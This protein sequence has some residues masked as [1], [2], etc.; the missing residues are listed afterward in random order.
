M[1][2]RADKLR[3]R[4]GAHMAE[5]M[6][7]GATEEGPGAAASPG[8]TAPAAG[9]S[10]HD[11]VRALREARTI[12]LENLA[13]D[14]SQPRQQFDAESLDRLAK[15]LTARGQLQP[16]RVRWGQ[17]QGK[18]LIV[19]GER[20]WR[21]AMIAGMESLQ[22][23][24]VERE[25]S[26]SEIL[27]EQLVENCLREDLQ[28]IE[29]SRAFKALMDANGWSA[30]RVADELSLANSTVVKAL[31]LLELA[32]A[33][34]ERVGAGELSPAAAYEVSKLEDPV[35]QAEVAERVVREKLTRDQAAA[36]V[37]EK[38]GR[39]SGA[40]SGTPRKAD[41]TRP[42]RIEYRLDDGTTVTIS[43]PAAASG[44]EAV[45]AALE[46]ALDRAR[47]GRGRDQAA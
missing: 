19:A 46:Q 5:S 11:G 7:A 4:L 12:R 3:D 34:Q 28:P 23:V 27:Q 43:S 21:A 36:A 24:V 33:V 14:P 1:A 41:T 15:S 40:S 35:Q 44:P 17:E 47:Q 45:I 10:K 38:S 16:I 42:A 26:P 29:Q 13:R 8:S 31:A 32:P 20:R 18:Y 37:R 6:G 39:P 25:L 30:R 9:P 22:A 2:S